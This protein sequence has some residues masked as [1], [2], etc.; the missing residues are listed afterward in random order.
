LNTKSAHDIWFVGR[1]KGIETVIKALPKVIEKHPEVIYMVLGKTHPN[2]F[3][4]SGE[5]YRI[6]LMRLVKNLQLE[7]H[8]R[9]FK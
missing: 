6:F 1:N 8:C 4:H 5:E 9:F 3:R 2:V 7:K